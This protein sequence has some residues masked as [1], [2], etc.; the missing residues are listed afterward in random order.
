M[1]RL[2]EGGD[3]ERMRWRH[4]ESGEE[5]V[6]TMFGRLLLKHVKPSGGGAYTYLIPG[7]VRGT[8]EAERL[9]AER[10]MERVTNGGNDR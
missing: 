4:P 2:R 9:A 3:S 6:L 5:V 10:G 8:D 7:R 1:A